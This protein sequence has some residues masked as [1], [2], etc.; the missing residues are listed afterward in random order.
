MIIDGGKPFW[1]GAHASLN[2]LSVFTWLVGVYGVLVLGAM[3]MV[4]KHFFSYT[5]H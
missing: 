3:V 5:N 4:D 2:S 1:M